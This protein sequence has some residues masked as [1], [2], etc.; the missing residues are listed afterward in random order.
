L[1]PNSNEVDFGN[2]L[3]TTSARQTLVLEN[4]GQG[5]VNIV[6]ATI[7]GTDSG[8]FAIVAPLGGLVAGAGGNNRVTV[9]L[10]FSPDDT[11]YFVGE[12][13]P[14]VGT[15]VANGF[16]VE[17]R[18]R[19]VHQLTR[20]DLTFAGTGL[21]AGQ[22][23]DFGVRP[24][25]APPTILELKVRNIGASVR[26]LRAALGKSIPEFSFAPQPGSL[27]PGREVTIKVTFKPS[28]A[29]TYSDILEIYEGAAHYAAV[30]LKGTAE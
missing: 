17:L 30:V 1:V 9:T 12:F 29:G 4:V 7:S 16:P 5:D 2:V 24:V 21:G 10:S 25:S 14:Q 27:E 23:L 11:R 3:L 28:T 6:G 13:A 8:R 20:G 22:T 19:G 15:G 26:R 18:G